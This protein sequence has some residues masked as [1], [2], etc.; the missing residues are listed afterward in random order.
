NGVLLP[1]GIVSGCSKVA[2]T[3]LP[4]RPTVVANGMAAAINNSESA[5]A[6]E[7]ELWTSLTSS[8]DG[9]V[10]RHFNRPVGR[11]LSQWLIHT[12][13]SPNAV[14]LA[15]I[16]IGLAAAVCFVSGSYAAGIVGAVLF[17]ISAVI[18]CVD[19]DIARAVFKESPLGKWLDLAGD[20]VVHVAVFATIATGL[21]QRDNAISV[22]WLGL[23]AVA[24]ALLSFAVVVRGMKRLSEKPNTL[25]QRLIDS[26][27]NRDFSVLVLALA[28][29]NEIDL[30][31]WLVAIGSHAFWIALYW[32]QRSGSRSLR[33]R[34]P[35]P[36]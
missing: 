3:H 11:P 28:V 14:S 36:A 17:Q 31:L 5:R 18:D 9:Y 20:Q 8:S 2:L 15:S 10:D 30:F 23:S 35:T 13:V 25:L 7:R 19:G 33:A 12:S 26:A 24:G 32:L 1:I 34:V 27:T 22:L 6:S 29:A 4:T 21:Y 16:L